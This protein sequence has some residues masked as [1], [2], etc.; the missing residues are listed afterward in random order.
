MSALVVTETVN[1]C[2]ASRIENHGVLDPNFALC[3][4]YTE[5]EYTEIEKNGWKWPEELKPCILCLRNMIFYQFMQAR[6]NNTGV[7]PSV[8]FAPIGNI[9]GVQGEYCAENCFLSKPDRYEGV[10]APVVIPNV[11]DYRVVTNSGI[12]FLQQTLPYPGQRQSNFF[13]LTQQLPLGQYPEAKK[14]GYNNASTELLYTDS[15]PSGVFCYTRPVSSD[16]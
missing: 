15:H 2:F 10:L 8:I 13:F 11:M 12:R 7:L 16:F 14:D 4:F 9:V 5:K 3:E 6:C 1:N